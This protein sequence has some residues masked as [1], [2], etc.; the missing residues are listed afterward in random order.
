MHQKSVT[1]VKI[2]EKIV[3]KRLQWY[4]TKHK[5]LLQIQNGFRKGRNTTH[6]ILYMENDIQKSLNT[7]GEALAIFMD[8]LK[9]YDR[10][11]I[12]GLLVKC[13]R[14]GLRGKILS[15]IQSFLS[16]R[17]FQ[18]RIENTESSTRTLQNGLPQGCILSPFLFN[19]ML[20]DI[21]TIPTVHSLLF[22]DDYVMWKSGRNTKFLFD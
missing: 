6:N 11:R 18:V 2:M 9:A 16:I 20:H 21:P 22:A 13:A 10:L 5:I 14:V 15:F 1:F 7:K 8:L 17:T 4:A 3:D 19:L 12:K